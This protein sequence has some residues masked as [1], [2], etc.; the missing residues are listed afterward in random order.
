[1]VI[2][3]HHTKYLIS[4]LNTLRSFLMPF[5]K[6]QNQVKTLR[7]FMASER[8]RYEKIYLKLEEINEILSDDLEQDNPIKDHIRESIDYAKRIK[9]YHE[10][11]AGIQSKGIKD[12]FYIN[13]V[14]FDI[15]KRL[16]LLGIRPSNQYKLILKFYKK[17]DF[18]DYNKISDI[19]NLLGKI[20]ANRNKIIKDF[21][22]ELIKLEEIRSNSKDK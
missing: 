18:D 3:S 15:Y 12:S 17:Y 16:T 9:N 13:Q 11:R 20:R 8:R 4:D 7:S 2:D 6:R 22:P 10:E 1:M 19:S 21:L 14:L 5:H